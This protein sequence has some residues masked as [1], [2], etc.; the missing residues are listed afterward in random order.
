MR[1]EEEIFKQLLLLKSIRTRDKDIL[2]VILP[3][4]EILKW[5]LEESEDDEE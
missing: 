5:V 4:I 1:S 3:K 2:S